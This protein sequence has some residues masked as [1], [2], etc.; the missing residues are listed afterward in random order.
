MTKTNMEQEEMNDIAMLLCIT[1]KGSI[2][3][4][5]C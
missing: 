4:P 3:S 5:K 2:L 1:L